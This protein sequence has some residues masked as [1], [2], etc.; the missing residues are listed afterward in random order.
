MCGRL[1]DEGSSLET[2]DWPRINSAC[3]GS[4][5]TG[6]TVYF[7]ISEQ[8]STKCINL[9]NFLYIDYFSRA[10]MCGP[11]QYIHFH[12]DEGPTL[13]TLIKGYER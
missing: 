11:R 13:E 4:T 9:Y 12:S 10:I 7:R 1:S 6:S 3:I 8:Y 5:A 2:L